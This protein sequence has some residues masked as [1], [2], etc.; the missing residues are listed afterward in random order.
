MISILSGY[1]L[2]FNLSVIWIC[3]LSHEKTARPFPTTY[4][5]SW[6]NDNMS[7]W[8]LKNMSSLWLIYGKL[9]MLF[10]QRQAAAVLGEPPAGST[11]RGRTQH[12]SHIHFIHLEAHN[13]SLRSLRLTSCQETSTH[14]FV[15]LALLSWSAALAS[16]E[17]CCSFVWSTKTSRIKSVNLK[18]FRCYVTLTFF[19]TGLLGNLRKR[20]K[21]EG[22]I[23]CNGM[24]KEVQSKPDLCLRHF[25][26]TSISVLPSTKAA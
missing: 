4:S 21:N 9:W 13:S 6:S 11:E 14:D 7:S 10:R 16:S 3:K 22:K 8:H 24:E 23:S 2:N 5:K 12:E 17:A 19:Q 18:V 1:M 25:K 26:Q 20:G 15:N